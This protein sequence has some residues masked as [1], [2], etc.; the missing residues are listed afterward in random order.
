MKLRR[1]DF[2]GLC[3]GLTMAAPARAQQPPPAWPQRLVR[4]ILPFGPGSGLDITSRMFAEPL[5]ARWGKPVVIDNRPGGDGIVA[6]SAMVNA[7]DDHTLLYAA[8]GSFTVHPYVHAKLPYD[9]ARDLVPIVKIAETMVSFSVPESL[10]IGSLKELMALARAQ[11]GKLN[12]ATAAG[13]SDFVLAGYFKSAGL[14]ITAVPYRDITKAPG[15]LGEGRIQ[16]LAT[17]LAMAQPSAQAGKTRIIAVAN[18]LRSPAAPDVPTVTEAGFPELA[19]EAPT[20]VFGPRGIAREVRERIAADVGAV[21]AAAPNIVARMAAIGQVVQAQGPD[22]FG[23]AIEQQRA[24]VAAIAQTLGIKP[25][26]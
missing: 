23:T 9:A 17:S 15:D 10:K 1:R 19:F 20:G 13:I 26:Q 8:V 22:A 3:A 2:I 11:P 14:D 25:K 5:A 21:M 6:I 7:N 16:L 24:R 18:G 4:L 12:Y